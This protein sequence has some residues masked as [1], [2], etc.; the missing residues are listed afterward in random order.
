MIIQSDSINSSASRRYRTTSSSIT[1]A[2]TWN[3]ATFAQATETNSKT[4]FYEETSKSQ[5]GN[6]L[7]LNEDNTP[8]F[9]QTLHGKLE[10]IQ[11]TSSIP[12]VQERL[13]AVRKIQQETINYLLNI[14]FGDSPRRP[15]KI[16]DLIANTGEPPN[17]SS[18][19]MPENG[20]GIGG[21]NYSYF[22][23]SESELTQFTTRGTVKTA[24]GRSINFNIEMTMSRSFY[25]ETE[26][27][28]EYGQ[29]NLCDP[30]VINL[31]TN[32]ASVSDQ[33]FYF[34]LDADGTEES[35]SMLNSN[36]GYLALDKNNNGI[37]DDGSELFGTKSGNGYADL[38]EYDIDKNGW[39][40]EADEIFDKLKIWTI[41]ENGN[42]KLCTLK[43]AGVGAIHLGY[44]NT[45]FSL[46]NANNETLGV[47]QKTGMF[48][49]EDGD[50]GTIQQV[51][52][53]V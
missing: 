51:D 11:Q 30:L 53:A 7:D 4:E 49:Y 19:E 24:D 23:Y 17:I 46:K 48:L 28:V 31:D 40:D 9:S 13:A 2:Q 26:S 34:D 36:T 3:N 8:S 42:S 20:L 21:K 10:P 6:L 37:I 14:L 35:I 41:D 12:S 1:H 38:A 22:S 47:I 5:N 27:Y 32:I 29:P 25:E 50:V 44:E 43:D 52:F 33:K 18:Q 45:P 16:Q 15:G 39:I